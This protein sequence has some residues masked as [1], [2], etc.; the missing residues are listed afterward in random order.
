MAL[1]AVVRSKDME[2][3]RLPLVVGERLLWEN[4]FFAQANFLAGYM[5]GAEIR[6]YKAAMRWVARDLSR[7]APRAVYLHASQQRAAASII[8]RDR[9][10]EEVYDDKYLSY[11]MHCYFVGLLEIELRHTRQW[12]R[13]PTAAASPWPTF[14]PCV[15]AW[16]KY[17][18]WE[19]VAARLEHPRRSTVRL[20]ATWADS[21]DHY[22]DLDHYL[23][24]R[25]YSPEARA[26]REKYF[27][28]LA[29]DREVI[30]LLRDTELGEDTLCLYE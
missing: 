12:P 11:Q 18:T 14:S 7:E 4:V 15:I 25:P 9:L 19:D 30:V 27:D 28:D 17:G 5:S 2:V 13:S 23:R 16:E 20:V 29:A 1:G 21:R 26:F 3:I 10:G 24:L 8:K 6:H 22:F